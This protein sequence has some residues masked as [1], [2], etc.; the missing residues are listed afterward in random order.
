MGWRKVWRDLAHNRLRTFLVVISIAVGVFAVGLVLG[1][2]GVMRERMTQDFQAMMPAHINFWNGPFD[3]AVVEAVS[4]QPGVADVEAQVNTSFRWKLDGE[5]DWRDAIL[6]ARTDYEAQP[7]D[8]IDLLSGYWPVNRTLAIE[9]QASQYFDIPLGTTILV[10]FGHRTRSLP[11][12]GIVRAPT[13]FP[14]QF[15]GSATFYTTPNT[16]SWLTGREGSNSL[17]IRL[18]SFSEEEAKNTAERIK[19]RLEQAKLS[20]GGPQI[21]DPNVHF[22]QKQVD[23]LFLILGVLGGLS[24]GLSAFLIVNT[25]NAIMAQQVWQIGVMKVIGAT[26]AH[27]T[28]IY[29]SGALFYGALALL[30]AIPLGTVATHLMAGWMLSL[31]SIDQGPFRLVPSAIVIQIIVGMAVPVLAALPPVIGGARISPHQAIRT[32][33]LGVGFGQ[34]WLDRLIGQVSCL[35]CLIALSLRNTLRRKTRVLLTLLTLVLSGVMF[36]VVMSVGNSLNNTIDVLLNDLGFDAMLSFDRLHRVSDL[37][38]ISQSVPGVSRAEVWDYRGAVLSLSDDKEQRQMYL[39]GVP[40]NSRLFRPQI[41]SGRG[42]LPGDTHAILLNSKISADE[43]I[44]VGDQITLTLGG[45]KSDWTVAGLV[46]NVNNNQRDN[47]VPLDTLARETGSVNRGA[48]VMLTCDRH[49]AG[50]D[51]TLMRNLRAAYAARHIEELDF[52]SANQ[53]REQGKTQ[54]NIITYLMLSMAI[55]AAVVGSLGLMGALSLNVVERGREIGVMRAIGA[56]SPAVAGIFI[57]EGVLIGVL[58]W[59]IALPLSYPGAQAF[60]NL[61][62]GMLMSLPLNFSYSASGVLIWLVMVVTLSTLASL[63]PA[64]RAT[65]LSVNEALAYE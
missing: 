34:N 7:M 59:L 65:R 51:Q 47:F 22:L 2:S 11:V 5:V 38:E 28:R 48:M 10:E 61:V 29:L 32:W 36:I 55:L 37:I 58:S 52:Q 15:G 39:W 35:P 33:G 27:V 43:G 6:I 12:E 17:T 31:M 25:M 44:R 13:I 53:V 45:R 26:F 60:S 24:L 57:C 40:A 16:A 54:F 46:L 1:L 14:P 18:Q 19:R 21:T 9:R 50:D 42:L 8:R 23:T 20:I 49:K 63:L 41:V 4:Q 3:Q 64:M 30:V 56:T 62:G